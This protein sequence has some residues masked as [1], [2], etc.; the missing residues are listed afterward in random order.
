LAALPRFTDT[1]AIEDDV[2][3]G[4]AGAVDD[5]IGTTAA[6]AQAQLVPQSAGGD[7]CETELDDATLPSPASGSE[8]SSEEEEVDRVTVP[9]PASGSEDS[10]EEEVDRV[11]VPMPKPVALR[12]TSTASSANGDSFDVEETVVPAA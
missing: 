2:E 1:D 11:T 7:V 6:A 4:L 3:H 5:A 12:A 9:M 8:D 10:S